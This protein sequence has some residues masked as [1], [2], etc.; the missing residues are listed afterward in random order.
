MKNDKQYSYVFG[1]GTGYQNLPG[2]RDPERWYDDFPHKSEEEWEDLDGTWMMYF[3][4]E[5]WT[6]LETQGYIELEGPG[7]KFEAEMP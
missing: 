1:A 3:T 6:K 4:E 7:W 2:W 5:E